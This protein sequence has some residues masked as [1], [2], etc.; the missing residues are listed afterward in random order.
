[1]ASVRPPKPTYRPMLPQR[2]VS[3][4]LLSDAQLESVVYAGEA[5][6]DCL[7]G[8]W[9]VNESLDVLSVASEDDASAVAFRRGWFLGDGTGA[10]SDDEHDLHKDFMSFIKVTRTLYR[11][12]LRASM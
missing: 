12:P 9:T 5:H 10:G 1:M 4:G 11:L 6:A 2:V 3:E 8:R 7:A